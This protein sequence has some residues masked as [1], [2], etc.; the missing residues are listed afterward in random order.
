MSTWTHITGTIRFD[1]IADLMPSPELGNTCNYSS[2]EKLWDSCNVPC[3][4]EGS[5]QHNLQ[6]NPDSMAKW[7]ATF[8]GDLRDYEDEEEV[9]NY[10]NRIVEG[11]MIRQGIFSFEVESRGC[12]TFIYRGEGFVEL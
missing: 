6:T 8:W 9:I 5:L 4:S 11:R 7:V 10:F 1:G 2:E 3:G 12:R